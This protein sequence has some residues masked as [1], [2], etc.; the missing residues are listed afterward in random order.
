MKSHVI[1]QKRHVRV[2]TNVVHRHQVQVYQSSGMKVLNAPL[3]TRTWVRSEATWIQSRNCNCWAAKFQI[4]TNQV[5]MRHHS[6]SRECWGKPNI[7]VHRWSETSR[8]LIVAL[9]LLM[10]ILFTITIIP[11]R[12]RWTSI[13]MKMI[14]FHLE[15]HRARN[16]RHRFQGKESWNSVIVQW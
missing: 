10:A 5:A 12:Q 8:I 3:S 9:H 16:Q 4:M 14:I 15:L 7:N 6:I 2:C 13:S 1:C 11:R